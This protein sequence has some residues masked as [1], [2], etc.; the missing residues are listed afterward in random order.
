MQKSESRDLKQSKESIREARDLR[1][2]KSNKKKWKDKK[3][4]TI[5]IAH[6]ENEIVPI[7][8]EEPDGSDKVRDR[9]TRSRAGIHQPP[10]A[11]IAWSPRN[12]FSVRGFLVQGLICRSV[13]RFLEI[14]WPVLVRGYLAFF[15]WKFTAFSGIW[16]VP[17]GYR[18]SCRTNSAQR[19]TTSITS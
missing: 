1:R 15:S 3:A 16:N 12:N 7:S 8:D 4:L 19:K 2:S 10:S 13:H 17:S 14:V 18:R 11:R 5:T 9:L 6:D